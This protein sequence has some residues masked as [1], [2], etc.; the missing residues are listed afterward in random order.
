[1][2]LSVINSVIGTNNELH[3]YIDTI[4]VNYIFFC[5]IP[6]LILLAQSINYYMLDWDFSFFLA[7]F[8]FV[9]FSLSLCL[10][11]DDKIKSN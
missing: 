7:K 5:S 10:F 11:F 2:Q 1:M 8:Y 4:A 9:L 3:I 6:C